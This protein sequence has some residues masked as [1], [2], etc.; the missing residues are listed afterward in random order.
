MLTNLHPSHWALT[1][2]YVYA[3]GKIW[4]TNELVRLKNW[5]ISSLLVFLLGCSDNLSCKKKHFLTLLELEVV[6]GIKA[7]DTLNRNLGK[8]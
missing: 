1:Y 2:L 5:W 8:Q 7:H 4:L 3:I 6:K